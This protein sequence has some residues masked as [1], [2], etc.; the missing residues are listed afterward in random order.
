[1][2][3]LCCGVKIR[4]PR[5]V[6][7]PSPRVLDILGIVSTLVVPEQVVLILFVVD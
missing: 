5:Q 2:E 3:V 4:T 6:I 1:M 7:A